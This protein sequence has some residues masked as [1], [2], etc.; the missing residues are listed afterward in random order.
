MVPI[1]KLAK[2]CYGKLGHVGRDKIERVKGEFQGK[3]DPLKHFA[4]LWMNKLTD[5]AVNVISREGKVATVFWGTCVA[6]ALFWSGKSIKDNTKKNCSDKE[7]AS[8]AIG[9]LILATG[10]FS[11]GGSALWFAVTPLGLLSVTGGVAAI[12]GGIAVNVAADRCANSF[13]K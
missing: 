3:G 5:I 10:A 11:I 13:L 6:N 7:I 9:K 2:S 8:R 1:F 12:S 4:D